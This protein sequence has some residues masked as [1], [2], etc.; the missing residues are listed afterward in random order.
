MLY[1]P[2]RSESYSEAWRE[3]AA[4]DYTVQ[5]SA[6]VIA[7]G[8]ASALGGYSAELFGYLGH[9]CLAA[10][11]SFAALGAVARGFPTAAEVQALHGRGAFQCA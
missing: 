6:V 3:S 4:T 8:A 9:F 1:R 11:A 7:T 2:V 10:A 5:A